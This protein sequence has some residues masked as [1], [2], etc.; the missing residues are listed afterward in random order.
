MEAGPQPDPPA[1][2]PGAVDVADALLCV[3]VFRRAI[4]LTLSP[5]GR[6]Y[7]V[8]LVREASPEPLLSL[9]LGHAVA[10]RL[11][12]MGGLDPWAPGGRLGRIEARVGGTQRGVREAAEHR[13]IALVD[14]ESDHP[15]I[16]FV[17]S[18]PD[19]YFIPPQRLQWLTS[20]LAGAPVGRALADAIAAVRGAKE[21]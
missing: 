8:A 16:S 21:G 1:P 15:G 5:N 20:R 4:A 11:G 18:G 7:E 12:L 19:G 3:L 9:P 2:R 17:Q 13:R 6:E 10:A 14:L